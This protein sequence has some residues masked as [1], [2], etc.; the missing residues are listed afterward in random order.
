MKK[1]I[2][3]CYFFVL[4]SCST[5]LYIPV[6]S[7]DT[8]SIV[9]LKQGRQ[10]YVNNCASCHQLYLPNKF[11][12]KVWMDNLNEMQARA[13]ITDADKKLIYQYLINAPKI[14]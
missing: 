9:E 12:N 6:E 8:T 13:K 3:Y 1:I 7:T 2:H 10:A 4:F 14:K 11:D 5:Q